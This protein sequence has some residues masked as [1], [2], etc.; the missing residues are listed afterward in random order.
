MKTFCGTSYYMAP[1][2]IKGEEYSELCDLWSAGVILYIML[3]GEPPFFEEDDDKVLETIVKGDLDF[4]DP[5]WNC[6]SDDAKD[7]IRNL[8]VP[9]DRRISAHKAL[10]HKFFLVNNAKQMPQKLQ[11]RIVR[12]LESYR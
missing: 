12:R 2:V 10:Q 1:E 6:I 3:S 11:T 5:L 8:L 9:A 7:L 4:S